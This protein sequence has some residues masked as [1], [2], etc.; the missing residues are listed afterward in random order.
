MLLHPLVA[1]MLLAVLLLRV[2]MAAVGGGGSSGPMPARLP[3]RMVRSPE[4]A[5][6][7]LRE[8]GA[9]TLSPA[10]VDSDAIAHID[11]WL[12]RHA[13]RLPHYT[14]RQPSR[15][16]HLLLLPGDAGGAVADLVASIL[17]ALGPTVFP[18]AAVLAELGAF[19]VEPGAPPQELHADRTE[20]GF[21]SCQIALHD[22]PAPGGGGLALWPGTVGDA[23]WELASSGG[24]EEC[25]LAEFQPRG[26]VVCYDGRL[27]HHGERHA[28]GSAPTRRV[29]Y[30]SAILRPN[31]AGSSDVGVGVAGVAAAVQL[32]EVA[33]HPRLRCAPL[34]TAPLLRL[35][36]LAANASHF[37]SLRE[38][39]AGRTGR[40]QTVA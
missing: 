27:W 29:L 14:V 19:V 16:Q 5:L 39:C 1:T 31:L 7:A 28:G 40:L 35:Q 37:N 32:G 4:A 22:T 6:A 34:R 11:G 17:R 24:Q 13:Q 38:H 36:V 12:L 15:R 33:M 3:L 10:A 2:G 26:G 25:A 18:P 20:D 23:R 8:S 21:V 9:F 30:F